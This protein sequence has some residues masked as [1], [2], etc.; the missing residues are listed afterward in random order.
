MAKIK[1]DKA[2]KYF[3][4]CVRERANWSC[5]H[6]QTEFDINSRGSL[7]CA[8]IYGRVNKALRQEPLNAFALCFSC[9]K[10]FSENPCDFTKFIYKK[11]G[12]IK[13]DVLDEKRFNK[14]KYDKEFIDEAAEHYKKE[15]AEMRER[16]EQGETGRIEFV[17]L[18]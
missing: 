17:G 14:V 12:Q 9:H 13:L 18:I 16:R 2:D 15:F 4:L 8:H 7:Q 11:L 1:I 6:C 10:L 5:E 3:S